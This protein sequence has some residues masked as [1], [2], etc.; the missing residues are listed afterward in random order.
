MAWSWDCELSAHQRIP[1]TVV[2]DTIDVD[3]LLLVNAY[4]EDGVLIAQTKLTIEVTV[5]IAQS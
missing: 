3:E 1:P 5:S 4:Q 2:K